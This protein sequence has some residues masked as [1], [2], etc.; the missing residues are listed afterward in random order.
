MNK[1]V[2]GESLDALIDHR[3]KT[4]KKLGSDFTESGVPVAS[5]ILVA[6]G[7]LDLSSARRVSDAIFR[8]WM[9]I[10]V[11]EGDV[12]LTSEAPL[13]RVARVPN[14]E[15]LVLGQRLFG[16]RGR[17]G[18]LDNGYLYYALQTAQVRA[19]LV[20]HATGTTVVGI[21]QSA[22]RTVK[23]PAP[24][25]AE[26]RAIAEVLG[27]LDD[28]IAANRKADETIEALLSAMFDQLA[29]RGKDEGQL[30]DIAE[31]NAKRAKPQPGGE[32]RYLDI[33]SVTD[34]QYA[35]PEVSLWDDAPGRARRGLR[36]G[37]VVWS[38]VRPNR[39]SHALVLDDDTRLVASTGLAV[40]SPRGVSSAYL[41]QTTKTPKF[42][43]YL[44]SAAEGSAYPAVRADRFANAPVAILSDEERAA[45][46]EVAVSARDAQHAHLIENE[47]LAA[48]RDGLLPLLMSGKL[49]VKDAEKQVG[50]VV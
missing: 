30:A 44:E 40:L 13:G 21:R 25:F 41:Y 12:L 6:E 2:L 42:Q 17:A 33:A 47:K 23:I 29:S 22:L 39:R 14:D 37:D 5:A 36:A 19:E 50:E 24:A 16:L 3:G 34:G 20:G 28:K 38:T 18:V 7:V 49:R 32:L 46:D 35:P 10:P 1:L 43:Q 31:I 45:F 8:K 26:Q 11:Q 15:P 27:A 48:T 9:P 4:P